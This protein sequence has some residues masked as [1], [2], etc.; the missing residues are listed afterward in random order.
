MEGALP[1]EV[2]GNVWFGDLPTWQLIV[3]IYLAVV[4][5]LGV[6]VGVAEHYGW[7]KSKRLRRLI[8]K[9]YGLD[10]DK[11]RSDQDDDDLE[12]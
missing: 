3:L 8:R 7:I 4:L 1:S 9:V 6:G 11:H 5:L 10:R 2:L 12:K